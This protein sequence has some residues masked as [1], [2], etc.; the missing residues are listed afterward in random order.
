MYSEFDEVLCLTK[1]DKIIRTCRDG[2]QLLC[3]GPWESCFRAQVRECNFVL[4]W[5]QGCPN[6]AHTSFFLSFLSFKNF[7]C[8]T[9]LF[10]ILKLC[11]LS[12]VSDLGLESWSNLFL[13]NRLNLIKLQRSGFQDGGGGMG[14]GRT[15]ASTSWPRNSSTISTSA[16]VLFCRTFQGAETAMA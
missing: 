15:S 16:Q 13:K 7:C 3:G 5:H 4:F 14:G 12:S 6:C 8:D 9:R 10:W 11:M 2:T 1:F